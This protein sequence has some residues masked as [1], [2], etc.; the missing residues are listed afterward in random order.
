MNLSNTGAGILPY[1]S[2]TKRFLVGL[3]SQ[4]VMIPGKWGIFG[5][6]LDDSE[7][8]ESQ[9]EIGALRELE[10]ETKF[11]ASMVLHHL[12]VFKKEFDPGHESTVIGKDGITRHFYF[13]DNRLVYHS[14]LGVVEEEFVP[15]LNWENDDAKWIT[16]EELY[17]LE[18]LHHG[19][20]LFLREC[21]E[22]IKNITMK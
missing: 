19:L 1:C 21:E 16:H 15:S 10:E 13:L 17:N 5:G 6:M 22:Q 12:Y 11:S 8:E 20:E 3:R 4:D 18:P 2:A 9:I 14:F 7:I